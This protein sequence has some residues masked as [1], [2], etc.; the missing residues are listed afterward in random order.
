MPCAAIGIDDSSLARVFAVT[1]TLASELQARGIG[2]VHHWPLGV[3][4]E[5][6]SPRAV[7][8]AELASLPRP[9]MLSVGRVAVEKN[10]DAFLSLDLP[11]SKVIV[12]DGPALDELR[13]YAAYYHSFNRERA[14][15][16]TLSYVVTSARLNTNL[17]NLD[18]W[19]ERDNGER[20]GDYTLYRVK[21]RSAA[22]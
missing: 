9:I 12:G 8:L 10:L 20:F 17:S 6:F 1:R 5:Q 2:P 13:R 4:L 16:P 19:Y 22:K 7:P 14:A 15:H 3:D 18:R 11:G 21:L